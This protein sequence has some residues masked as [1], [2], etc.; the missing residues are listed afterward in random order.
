MERD[1]AWKYDV[2]SYHVQALVTLIHPK[3]ST[4][5]DPHGTRIIRVYT[6]PCADAGPQVVYWLVCRT[7][8]TPE[9]FI[10]ITSLGRTRNVRSESGTRVLDVTVRIVDS[11]VETPC[12]QVA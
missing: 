7:S 10:S 9:V 5:G 2:P 12:P 1:H 6:L 4:C 11:N 3:R 8:V